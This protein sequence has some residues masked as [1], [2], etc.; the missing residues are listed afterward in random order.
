MLEALYDWLRTKDGG[1]DC[2]SRGAFVFELGSDAALHRAL[3]FAASGTKRPIAK[4][5]DVFMRQA[6]WARRR[7]CNGAACDRL[8]IRALTP[9]TEVP[10]SFVTSCDG[11]DDTETKRVALT[12][13][14]SVTDD[15]DGSER[16]YMY[17]KLER[18]PSLSASHIRDAARRYLLK[19]AAPGRREN[20]YIDR[21]RG[22][23]RTEPTTWYDAHVRTGD[24]MFVPADVVD[25]VMR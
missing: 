21:R 18:S 10:I 4:T 23:P 15:A 6:S 5:H 11:G 25:A 14:F 17:L 19:K 2:F 20:A 3:A 8:R 7:A 22:V 12:Y 16:P 24:E 13:V 9:Q 1:K